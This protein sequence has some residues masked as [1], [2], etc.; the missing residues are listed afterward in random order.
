VL[1]PGCMRVGNQGGLDLLQLRLAVSEVAARVPRTVLGLLKRKRWRQQQRAR[2]RP[3]RS[4]TYAYQ[5]SD[6]EEELRAEGKVQ[7]IRE[8]GASSA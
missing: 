8:R 2:A 6:V 4:S 5:I 3:G 7:F 1:D